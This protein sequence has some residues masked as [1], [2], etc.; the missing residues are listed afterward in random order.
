MVVLGFLKTGHF[1]VF[2]PGP[3]KHLG[4]FGDVG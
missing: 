3:R 2:C 1:S 4:I